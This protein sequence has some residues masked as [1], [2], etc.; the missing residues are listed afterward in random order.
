M[1]KF[2]QQI[3]PAAPTTDFV[4]QAQGL[5]YRGAD[6]RA[7]WPQFLALAVIG[8]TLFYIALARFRRTIGSMA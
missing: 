3:M 4:T 5:L 2:V 6:L 7:V 1:Q 8:T